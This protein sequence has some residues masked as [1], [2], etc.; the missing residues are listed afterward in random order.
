MAEH[1]KRVFA[2]A[3]SLLKNRADAEDVVQDVFLRYFTDEKQFAS[4]AHIRAWLLRTAINRAKDLL[5]AA[6][7]QRELPLEDVPAEQ[8]LSDDESGALFRAVTALP[9][10]YRIVIHLHYY[11]D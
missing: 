6:R 5:R 1:G 9:E 4:E 3:Y 2:A 8:E 10:P 7:R 11:E